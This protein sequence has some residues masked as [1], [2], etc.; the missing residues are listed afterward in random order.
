M[1]TIDFIA[2]RL[3]SIPLYVRKQRGR[4]RRLVRERRELVNRSSVLVVPLGLPTAP[5]DFL[6]YRTYGRGF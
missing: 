2:C 4:R 5:E 3:T 6:G 1:R